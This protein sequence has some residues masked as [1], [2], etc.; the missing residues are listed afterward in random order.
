MTILHH[1]SDELL[2]GHAAGRLDRGAA[3][4]VGA[5]LAAC[6]AQASGGVPSAGPTAPR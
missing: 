2:L 4:V 5:H 3:L 1:P 6:P